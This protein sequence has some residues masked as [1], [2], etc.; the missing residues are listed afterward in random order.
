MSLEDDMIGQRLGRVHQIQA[1]GFKPYGHRFD[2]SHSIPE[3]LATYS[4]KTGEEL[5]A[6][7]VPVKIAGRIQTLRRMGKAGFAHLMQRAERL[8][9]YIKKDAIAERE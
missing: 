1:L 3:I 9:V 2:A 5:E 8:Q 7:R 6:A 4:V